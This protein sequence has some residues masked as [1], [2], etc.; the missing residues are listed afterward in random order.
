MWIP[1]YFHT[2][3]VVKQVSGRQPRIE[4]QPTHQAAELVDRHGVGSSPPPL[5]TELLANK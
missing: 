3:L 1:L 5:L 2:F 4:L